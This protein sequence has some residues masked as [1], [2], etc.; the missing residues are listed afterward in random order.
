MLDYVVVLADLEARRAQLDLAIAALR[1]LV[2][3]PAPMTVTVAAPVV[4]TPR[5]PKPET[6]KA[7]RDHED[8]TALRMQAEAMAMDGKRPKEIALAVGRKVSTIYAWSSE[9]KWS[10]K[11]KAASKPG[12]PAL[13]PLLRRCAACS[14]KTSADG[15]RC[16]HCGAKAAA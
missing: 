12:A 1:P 4:V 8:E 6:V 10:A 3:Q 13:S 14:Q 5:T 9:G 2:G 7:V 16:S 15:I 11:R